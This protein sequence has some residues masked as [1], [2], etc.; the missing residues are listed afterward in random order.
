MV[1]DVEGGLEVFGRGGGGR[2]LRFRFR[3]LGGFGVCALGVRESSGCCCCRSVGGRVRG[4][5]GG[6]GRVSPPLLG[7]P[8]RRQQR[9]LR[10]G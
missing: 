9:R 10:P 1:G 3:F 7:P 2:G 6:E 5:V 8:S 4:A